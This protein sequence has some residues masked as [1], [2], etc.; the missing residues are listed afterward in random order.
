MWAAAKRDGTKVLDCGDARHC[1]ES[2][3][4]STIRDDVDA[5]SEVD[6]PHWRDFLDRF[7]PAGAPGSATA[8]GIPVDRAAAAAAELMPLLVLLDDVQDEAEQLRRAAGTRAAT[9][10]RAGEL[11]AVE[12]VSRAREGAEAVAAQAASRTVAAAGDDRLGGASPAADDIRTRAAQRM[13]A[14]VDRAV[15]CAHDLVEELCESPA[16]EVPDR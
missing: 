10:L 11:E 4:R 16:A 2:P 15:A 1:I 6:M 12:I 13:P 5:R 3:I 9:M 14:Y 7:R 8:R